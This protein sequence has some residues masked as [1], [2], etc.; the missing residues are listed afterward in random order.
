M[1]VD[2]LPCIATDDQKNWIFYSK[3]EGWKRSDD[4]WD[5]T[6]PIYE[7]WWSK[8]DTLP[9][10]PVDGFPTKLFKSGV[11]AVAKWAGLTPHNGI[12]VKSRCSNFF[13]SFSEHKF[14]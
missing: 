12:N 4:N 8:F 14:L 9:D 1:F 2:E 7:G 6:Y 11:C 13:R 3:A 5:A 10:L